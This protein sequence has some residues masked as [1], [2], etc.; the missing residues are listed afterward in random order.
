VLELD[1]KTPTASVSGISLLK[2]DVAILTPSKSS[3]WENNN[4][5][6]QFCSEEGFHHANRL[7]QMVQ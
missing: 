5:S 3:T 2:S 4:V 7:S 1:K 6:D